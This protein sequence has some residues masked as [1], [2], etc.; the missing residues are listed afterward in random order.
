MSSRPLVTI[1]MPFR[2]PGDLLVEAVQS[3][4]CQTIDDWEL[5][6][7]DD[8][9]RD[10]ST[11]IARRIVDPRVRLISD[12]RALGLPKRLNQIIA[13]TR[14]AYIARM[15]A[16]DVMH[17]HRLE[18][19][20]KL[21]NEQRDVDLV[22]T[23][24]VILDRQRQPVGVRG[25][26]NVDSPDPLKSLL[27]GVVLHPSVLARREWYSRNTYDPEYP[28]AE[29]RELF[30]RA[31]GSSVFAHIP[32]ALH[33]YF[34]A[35]NVRPR[36]FLD[37]YKSERKVLLRYGPNL[38]GLPL[39]SLLWARSVA[40]SCVLP[41]LVAAGREDVITRHAYQPI[42]PTFAQEARKILER[43]RHQPVPGWQV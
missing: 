36:A 15:D 8:G 28:R 12:G 23:G 4:F 11:D 10:D 27:W 13:L 24:A 18:M 31:L 3:I 5:L 2:D 6:L 7:L 39:T 33:F 21:L 34:F 40:K 14:G 32:E 1:G 9:S 43:V 37:S 38:V 17:P 35:G 30:V 20:L 25:L 26:Q 22:D 19:Q 41:L 42:Q 16:D 29:D